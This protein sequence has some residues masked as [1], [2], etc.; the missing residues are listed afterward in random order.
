[1]H[2]LPYCRQFVK[3]VIYNVLCFNH[4][5]IL[6][7]VKM[8]LREAEVKVLNHVLKSS[9]GRNL[10]GQLCVIC[11]CRKVQQLSYKYS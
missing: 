3:A 7:T 4:V 8:A 1:M 5:K 2:D 10:N 6:G 11:Q 9:K